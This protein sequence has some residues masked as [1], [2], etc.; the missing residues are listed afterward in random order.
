MNLTGFKI[1]I[2]ICAIN[3]SA[4]SFDQTFKKIGNLIDV[5]DGY[6]ITKDLYITITAEKS[7]AG[8]V[9]FCTVYNM[10]IASVGPNLDSNKI[11]ELFNS[12]GNIQNSNTFSLHILILF[13]FSAT[14]H[15]H[16]W[17]GDT[18]NDNK[19]NFCLDLW[20]LNNFFRSHSAYCDIP[21]AFVCIK[22]S[23]VTNELNSSDLNR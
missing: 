9:V 6:A 8:A 14:P 18:V 1:V 20:K 2:L 22:S 13:Y 10:E 17:I 21:A 3:Q 15:D 11:I 4:S 7:W 12:V 16:V 5:Y 23:N 19:P